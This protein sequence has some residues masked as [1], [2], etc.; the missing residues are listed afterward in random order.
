MLYSCFNFSKY[1]TQNVYNIS[2]QLQEY[3]YVP[4]LSVRH[5]MNDVCFCQLYL[6]TRVR[7]S[8]AQFHNSHPQAHQALFI[9]DIDGPSP[10]SDQQHFGK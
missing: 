8:S 7:H 4:V 10:Y 5:V 2:E 1:I 6:S 3:W 9:R